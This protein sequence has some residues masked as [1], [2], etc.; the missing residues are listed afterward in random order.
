M[1][2][3]KLPPARGE[4]F[5]ETEIGPVGQLDIPFEQLLEIPV[6]VETDAPA[7]PT[8][9]RKRKNPSP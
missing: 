2:S 6:E 8:S 5:A 9:T 7:S 4:P 3:G 1:L